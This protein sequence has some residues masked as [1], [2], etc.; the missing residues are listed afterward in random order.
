MASSFVKGYL[1]NQERLTAIGKEL[2][3][4][5]QPYL[6]EPTG[7]GGFLSHAQESSTSEIMLTFTWKEPVNIDAVALFPLRLF[8]D[9][10][11]GENLYWSGSIT[12]TAEINGKTESIAQRTGQP[13]IQR[14]LPELITFEPVTTRELIIHC[15]DLPQHPHEKW[16]AA[17]FAEICIFAGSDNVA[18]R[19]VCKTSSSRQG[20]H[21][22]AKEFLTDSQT[23]LGLPELNASSDTHVFIKKSGWGKTALPKPYILTC[24]YP[25]EIPIDAVRIDPAIEHS[26]GQS[27]PVRFIINLLDAEGR[28]VQTDDTYKDFPLR[29]PG[30]NPHFSYFPETT[31]QAVRLIVLEASRPVPKATSAIVISE[32][33][34]IHQGIALPR[35]TVIEEQFHGRKLRIALGDP[36]DS[37]A[38]QMLASANN[39]LTQSGR[40]LSLRQWIEGLVRRQLLLEEQM[41]LQNVQKKILANV[42][43]TLI[44]GSLAL[45]FL[46]IGSAV[47]LIVRNRIRMRREI[48]SDRVKIASDLHDDVGSNLGAIVLHVEKLQETQP[49][50]AEY[51][52]LHSILRL[53]RE[54]VFGL[55]EVL[56]T[57]APEVGRAQDIIAYMRELAGLLLGKTPIT[58]KADPSINQ[59][60]QDH[61]P[62]QKGL[63]LFYKEAIHN[64]KTHSQCSHVDIHF[65]RKNHALVLTIKD[66]GIGIDEQTLNK[67]RTLRTL[68]QRANWLHADLK[69]ESIPGTGTELTLSITK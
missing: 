59:I 24:T 38:K 29:N 45:L 1:Q 49:K 51:D 35:A 28:I 42:A 37:E 54:S 12:I 32:I 2:D 16:Y 20:Y 7:T 60:L 53:T 10:I 39:G 61:A 33:T 34:A 13:L 66:N 27:F 8:M 63:L 48:R 58:F 3:A 52:R 14:S 40:V 46:V 11:Y 30:L 25:Q 65:F 31:A 47:Y 62:L 50:P 22:L 67:P 4:L 64:A 55:R 57:T 68:K 36:L 9:E 21:V 56:R 5:P 23:P 26:Y 19:A 41:V 44:Y 43:K 17:G 15:T 18:P 6:R 69:I